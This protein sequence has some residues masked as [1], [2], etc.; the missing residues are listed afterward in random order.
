MNEVI[1]EWEW[2]SI[3]PGDGVEGSV[4]LDEAKLSILLLDKEDRSSKG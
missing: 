3:L 1:D 4:V 2:V